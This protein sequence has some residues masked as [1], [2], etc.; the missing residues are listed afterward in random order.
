M[1]PRVARRGEPR[2]GAEASDA[3]RAPRHGRSRAGQKALKH[4]SKSCWSSVGARDPRFRQKPERLAPKKAGSMRDLGSAPRPRPS[5]VNRQCHR[6]LPVNSCPGVGSLTHSLTHLPAGNA[7]NTRLP[8]PLLTDTQ[9]LLQMYQ[10]IADDRCAPPADRNL[11]PRPPPRRLHSSRLS[12]V[13]SP[14]EPKA[15]GGRRRPAQV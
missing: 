5:P 11:P 4:P 3:A 8:P 9:T 2:F 12:F 1:L 6:P 14:R 13:F 7:P 10:T 15:A